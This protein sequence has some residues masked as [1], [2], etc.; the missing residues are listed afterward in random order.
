MVDSDFSGRIDSDSCDKPGDS[1]LTQLNV[2]FLDWHNSES[3]QI[4]KLITWLNSD[5]THFSQ[6][7]QLWLAAHRIL[8]NVIK[9]CWPGGGGGVRL[10]V[11]VGWLFP[12]NATNKCKIITFSPQNISDLSLTQAVSSWLNSYSNDTISGIRLWLDS[13][14]SESNQIK[15]TIHKSITIQMGHAM[16]KY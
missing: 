9:S 10:N 12:C 16:N 6:L 11:A 2:F 8:P 7:S 5:P 13:F 1:A 3:I 14:E 15:L 4:P